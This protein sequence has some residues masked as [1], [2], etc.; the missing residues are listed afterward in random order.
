LTIAN[1]AAAISNSISNV[2]NFETF[3]FLLPSPFSAVKYW[4][5]HDLKFSGIIFYYSQEQK[6]KLATHTN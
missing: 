1:G 2:T 6:L 4:L 5:I 3:I